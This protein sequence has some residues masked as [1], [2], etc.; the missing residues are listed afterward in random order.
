MELGLQLFG[1][2]KLYHQDPDAF[3]GRV[4]GFGYTQVEPC[5]LFGDAAGMNPSLG[6]LI[7]KAC[8]LPRHVA[9]AKAHG[10]S[11]SSCHVFAADLAQAVPEMVK[12]AGTYGLTQFVVGYRGPFEQAALKAFAETCA[13]VADR[14][15][16]HKLELWL[17]NHSTDISAKVGGMSA[18]E[19]ILHECRGKLG[20]Q[21]DTGWVAFGGE[22]VKD[23]L[24]R[25]ESFVRSVHHKDVAIGPD[26]SAVHVRLGA[27]VV[28]TVS[29]WRFARTHGIG[30]VVDQDASDGDLMEDLDASARL[31][32]TLTL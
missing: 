2:M 4:A 17:H 23:F 15:A 5:I 26:G 9:L 28:D 1:C 27:G 32:Q 19:L 21:V 8:D 7:W 30:Q 10:L 31:L 24:A 3:L 29:A 14:L 18:Y 11:L 22:D 16:A 13:D 20:A 6:S 25:N 12:A